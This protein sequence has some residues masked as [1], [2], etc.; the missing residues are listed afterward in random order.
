MIPRPFLCIARM[1]KMYLRL[2]AACVL[3]AVAPSFAQ[4]SA[5]PTRE[6][7]DGMSLLVRFLTGTHETIRQEERLGSYLPVKVRFARLWPDTAA[8]GEYW[9][10]EEVVETEPKEKV[11]LQRV[12]RFT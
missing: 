9:L 5:E 10:Y 12:F 6:G 8:T 1:K 4:S 2:L 3:A 11:V 7:Q